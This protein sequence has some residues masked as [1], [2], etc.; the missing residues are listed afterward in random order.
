MTTRSVVTLLTMS[1]G[2]L[3]DVALANESL[4]TVAFLI[5]QQTQHATALL[6]LC[7]ILQKSYYIQNRH[8]FK[9]LRPNN[10]NYCKI[11]FVG[12]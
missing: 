7:T 1:Y 8:T 3:N 6:I 11:F 2:K 4:N 9:H 10:Q 5:T 12:Y